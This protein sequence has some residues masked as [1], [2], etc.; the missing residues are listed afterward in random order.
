MDAH[1]LYEST[2]SLVSFLT[3]I[4]PDICVTCSLQEGW[5]PPSCRNVYL[6]LAGT[7]GSMPLPAACRMCFHQ[8]LVGKCTCNLQ[9][10]KYAFPCGLQD[11][12]LPAACRNVSMPF[13]A[14]CRMWF[15]L[16][17][18]GCAFTCGLQ[19]VWERNSFVVTPM[20]SV[21][22]SE[23]PVYLIWCSELYI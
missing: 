23:L 5:L 20:S 16:R 15:S 7:N 17:L 6:R 14:A 18:A 19:A 13:P 3:V 12:V 22:L 1:T 21:L 11:V 10:C 4:L 8:W 9:E 2:L